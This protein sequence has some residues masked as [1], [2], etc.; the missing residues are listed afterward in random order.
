MATSVRSS[1]LR[2]RRGRF[3]ITR[4]TGNWRA[5]LSRAEAERL[6]VRGFFQD[7]LDRIEREP[8]REA[9]GAALEA[10]IPQVQER[11]ANLRPR[12][13]LQRFITINLAFSLRR[14]V[15]RP[16]RRGAY[17]QAVRTGFLCAY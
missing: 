5:A 15:R 17:R 7:V 11:K 13:R 9:L 12:R 6:I 14:S 2:V 1:S 8:V 4:R 16:C 3:W 10:R